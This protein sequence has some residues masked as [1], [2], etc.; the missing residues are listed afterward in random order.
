MQLW[1][2][3]HLHLLIQMQGPIGPWTYVRN[4]LPEQERAPFDMMSMAPNFDL[5]LESCTAD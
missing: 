5:L 1:C 4:H 2:A 3:C